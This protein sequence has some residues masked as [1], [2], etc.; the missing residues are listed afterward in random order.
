M[1]TIYSVSRWSD[2]IKTSVMVKETAHFVT[3]QFKSF[4]GKTHERREKKDTSYVKF[5]DTWEEARAYVVDRAEKRFKSCALALEDARHSLMAAMA[6][7]PRTASILST[8]PEKENH[9]VH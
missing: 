1:K 9:G 8:E 5:F 7:K 4:D 3:I 2:D 6:R